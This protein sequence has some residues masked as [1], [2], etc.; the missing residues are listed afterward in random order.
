[1]ENEICPL[2]NN[3]K[4]VLRVDSSAEELYCTSC[5]RWSFYGR[6]RNIGTGGGKMRIDNM[7]YILERIYEGTL[8]Q[9][10]WLEYENFN[11]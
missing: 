2:C 4:H 6:L 1:M 8:K 11:N 10:E 5:R 3:S 7:T 9:G